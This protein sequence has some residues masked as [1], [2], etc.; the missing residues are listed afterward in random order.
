V[1][2]RS[3]FTITTYDFLIESDETERLKVLSVWSGFRDDD[4]IVRPKQDDPR[5]RGVHEHMPFTHI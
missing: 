4:L 3:P 5:G 2:P 1:P